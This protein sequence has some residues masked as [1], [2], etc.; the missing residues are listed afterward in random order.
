MKTIVKLTNGKRI[1]RTIDVMKVCQ[2]IKLN[3]LVWQC[4]MHQSSVP[5][6]EVPCSAVKS[7]TIC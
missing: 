4:Y 1:Q 2:A 5:V 3:K 6:W 7:I